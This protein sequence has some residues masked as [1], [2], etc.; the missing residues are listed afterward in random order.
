MVNC[1]WLSGVKF[2]SLLLFFSVFLPFQAL[3]EEPKPSDVR[4]II[5]IS[6]SMKQTDPQNL[7]IPALNLLVELLPDGSQAGVWTFGRYVNMLV[8]LSAVDQGWRDQAKNKAQTI[9]SVG[10]QTNLTEA[11]EK[12]QWQMA[13]DSGFDH[14]VI[15]LTDGKLDMTEQGAPADINQREKQRL[16]TQVLPDYIAA[17]AKVHTLALS[18]AADEKMLQQI[19][20]ETGGL[21][22]K[23]GSADDLL[24]LFLKAFDRAVPAEQVPIT[25]NQFDI[26]DSV[27]EFTALIFR[28]SD[29]QPTTLISPDGERIDE[30]SSRKND[31]VR[32]HK[33]LNFDLITVKQ[34]QAGQW[35]A[36]A[37]IDPDNRVQILTDLKLRVTGLP[38][39]IFAGYPV[40]LE[41][42]LTEKDA[43]LND[44]TILA[45]TD[46]SIKVTA[47]DGRMGSKLLSDPEVLPEDGVFRESL[48]RLSQ[49]G[50]YQIEVLA[51]G[52]T[53]KRKQTLTAMLSEPLAVSVTPDYDNQIL[54]VA[55]TPGV[56]NIDTSLSRIIARITSP[57]ESSVIQSMEYMADKNQWVL[58][59]SA[60]KGPGEYGV[61]LNIRGVTD[62][63][64]TFKSKPENISAVF[65]LVKPGMAIETDP[66]LEHDG[67]MDKGM[68]KPDEAVADAGN[69]DKS[70]S[71]E[72]KPN[73]QPDAAPG[74]TPQSEPEPEPQ[75]EPEP[76]PEPEPTP[77]PEPEPVVAP[78]L[79]AKFEEQQESADEE[80]P[81][82]EEGIAWW[83][84]LLLALGN[85]AVFGGVGYWWFIKR[86]ANNPEMAAKADKE[87]RLP[88]DL[89]TPEFD[90]S[91]LDG[92]FDAFSDD[93][94]E[95]IAPSPAAPGTAAE[96]A[97][98]DGLGLDDDFAIDPDAGGDNADESWG[99]FDDPF[100]DS[101]EKKD[102][103]S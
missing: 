6:G 51:E 86:K 80:A 42:A 93:S 38:N 49:Q 87:A 66:A 40:N 97:S 37:D 83:V 4:I 20:L 36:D 89:E 60:D 24:K 72:P 62:N 31:L 98:D 47:P 91:E 22:L 85:I 79:A 95:E 35:A 71:M 19:S 12:A 23:A 63:G 11:L 14:S 13:A 53:F 32:W 2:F 27:Q 59:L 25:N 30:N 33:D 100:D 50:E 92:D 43:V 41:M 1:R 28:K 73:Q 7:R 5:D 54:Q 94:E 76:A 67:A 99:E 9:N 17:G 90:E 75:P 56:E 26:D 102:G 44:K 39:N 101:E 15:L 18:D 55:V 77:E 21:F 64:S 78:D 103:D 34:P 16:L 29:A 81:V 96:A 69:M 74:T 82:E 3:A 8:P 58:A 61:L 46:L 48:T 68:M 10:L 70:A 88:P 45:L 65:P 84:Y 57:D 52:R